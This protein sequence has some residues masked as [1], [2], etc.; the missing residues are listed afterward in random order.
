MKYAKNYHQNA[1]QRQTDNNIMIYCFRISQ[2][3][4]R[5]KILPK[6]ISQYYLKH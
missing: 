2:P 3:K 1:N 4:P 5:R 6:Q